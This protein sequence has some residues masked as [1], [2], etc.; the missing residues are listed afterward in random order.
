MPAT[1]NELKEARADFFPVSAVL[2][3][4]L[5]LAVCVFGAVRN[6]YQNIDR[7]QFQR[8]AAFYGTSFK[9]NV[10]RHVTSLAA[11]Q[12]FVL[13]AQGVTRWEFSAFAHQTLPRNSGFK[14]VLWVPR[15]PASG[16]PAYEE[17][18]HRDGL[19]G[20]QIRYLSESG[21]L[22][23]A[24]ERPS[25]RPVGYVE[26]FDGN[27]GLVGV[28]LSSNPL[29][30][31]LFDAA[32]R[33]GQVSA[34]PLLAHTVIEGAQGPVVL[35]AFPLNSSI[36][37]QRAADAPPAAQGYALGVLQL[38][39]I[40][41]ETMDAHAA[42]IQAAIAYG[43]GSHQVLLS[44]GGLKAAGMGDWLGGAIL[45]QAVPFE[46]AQQHFTL[47]L[48]S[49][50]HGDQLTR[51]YAP[52]GAALLVLALIALLV[53][54]MLT[55]ILRKRMVE[56]AVIAR[57][58]ELRAVNRTLTVEVEQRRQAEAR[59]RIA[60]DKA[61]SANRAKSAFM[62]TMSHELR[63]PLNAIIG[64][65]DILAGAAKSLDARF[66]D[67][68]AEIHDNGARLLELINDILDLVMM[69]SGD[70]VAGGEPIYVADCVASTV[71]RLQPLA[72]QAGVNLTCAV[73][74]GLPLL[75]GDSKRLQKALLHLGA[76]AVKFTGKGGMARIAAHLGADRRLVLEVCDNGPGMPLAEQARNL[77]I[78]SQQDARLA[79][80]HEGVGLGLALVRR[81]ADLH[82]A[83][84]EIRSK[85]GEGTTVRLSFPKERIGNALEVA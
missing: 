10:E 78:F 30:A 13:A 68:L 36:H 5:T 75:H 70:A 18:L 42:P 84:F 21:A 50:G 67:Y 57:T 64:F 3:L 33:T 66:A 32:D 54:N 60:R 8:D 56:R 76:N 44:A 82:Q 85:P 40:V 23:A 83:A 62:A 26:P 59:L 45:H 27:G 22:V 51:L 48:R 49:A 53:Q 9:N 17:Q 73:A 77:E 1:G 74:E 11:I 35:I 12:A 6:Y 47:A 72:D 15:V 61:E 65:S 43:A 28:D 31:Q 24:G 7:Q 4:G 55:T 79:R 38:D 63:T 71:A 2:V 69:E 46:I 39:R 14:A 80:G 81:V 16:R 29:Y 58:A 19:Y 41:A 20:L 34:S 37:V 25:Y 52:L